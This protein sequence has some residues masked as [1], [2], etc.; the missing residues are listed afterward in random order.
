M[1]GE[2]MIIIAGLVVGV[3]RVAVCACVLAGRTDGV[4]ESTSVWGTKVPE[5]QLIGV[6]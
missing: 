6:K 2:R 5:K 4:T 1:T 3:T